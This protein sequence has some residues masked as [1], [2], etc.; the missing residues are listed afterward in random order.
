LNAA[1]RSFLGHLLLHRLFEVVDRSPADGR[2]EDLDDMREQRC[3]LVVWKVE[4]RRIPA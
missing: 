4:F 2:F 1:V 3:Q